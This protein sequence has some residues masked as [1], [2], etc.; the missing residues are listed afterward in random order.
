MLLGPLTVLFGYVCTATGIIGVA[1]ETSGLCGSVALLNGPE[2]MAE[3]TFPHGLRNA[4]VLIPLIEDMLKSSALTA[5]QVSRLYVSVGPGSFTGLRI[6]LTAA[7]TWAYVTGATITP[8]PTARAM[9][10]NLPAEAS[11]AI[12][13]LDA[14]RGQVFTARY[15]RDEAGHW[16]EAE[17]AHLDTLAAMLGRAPRPVWVTGE[18]LPHHA[19]EEADGVHVVPSE[20]WA[21]RAAAVG[22]IGFAFAESGIFADPM[23]LVPLYVRLPEAVEKLEQAGAGK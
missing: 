4:A 1:I 9:V 3:R 21:S 14:K 15:C 8:V 6:G 2:V 13:A 22:T 7:K 19:V 11:T 10:E 12:T 23:S 20:R 5:A 18:G 16:Q 17:P